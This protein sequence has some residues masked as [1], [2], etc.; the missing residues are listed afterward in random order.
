MFN[1]ETVLDAGPV[2]FV[3][4]KAPIFQIFDIQW[5]IDPCSDK[6]CSFSEQEVYVNLFNPAIIHPNI[7]GSYIKRLRMVEL[8]VKAWRAEFIVLKFLNEQTKNSLF[9]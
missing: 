8:G 1:L 6:N 2:Q 7:R 3:S 4:I 5:S 9:R